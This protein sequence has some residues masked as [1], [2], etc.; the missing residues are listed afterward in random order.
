[1]T[2][3]SISTSQLLSVGYCPCSTANHLHS[4]TASQENPGSAI[5]ERADWLTSLRSRR[6]E[7]LKSLLHS[8]SM[9]PGGLLVMSNAT[10]L[11]PA[12]SLMMRLL[13]RSSR[14]YGKRAQSAVIASS[15]VT[16]LITMG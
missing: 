15:E 11:T 12:T 5:R 2:L 6:A 9:V 8:H 14:S 3:V 4:R 10:R 7:L 16:A 13:V 1:M